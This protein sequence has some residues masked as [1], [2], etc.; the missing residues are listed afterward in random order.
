MRST[1][2]ADACH[3]AY[4]I[5]TQQ[6]FCRY[7]LST[8]K[9]T[10]WSPANSN[11]RRSHLWQRQKTGVRPDQQLAACYQSVLEGVSWSDVSTSPLL[12]ALH[13]ATDGMLSIEFNCYGYGRDS[14]IPR[15]TMGHIAGT[16]GPYQHGE[17]KHFV[18]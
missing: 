15:D 8:R 16:I 17:P 18:T 2:S 11:R 4:T 1:G 5:A 3:R 14:T 7:A 13:D 9:R 10:P 6:A 12:Q